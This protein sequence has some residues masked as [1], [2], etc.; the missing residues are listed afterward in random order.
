MYSRSFGENSA[1]RPPDPF[2]PTVRSEGQL[3]NMQNREPPPPH[4][5]ESAEPLPPPRQNGGLLEPFRRTL[6]RL[7]TD[8]L[9]LMAIGILI[10]LDG[11]GSDDILAVFILAL[12]LL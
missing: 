8:D 7:E 1:E 2:G 11:D 9:L 3:Y 4:I 10:L 12:L 5:P 6:G